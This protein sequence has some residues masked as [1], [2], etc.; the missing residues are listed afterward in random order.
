M[1][2]MFTLCM[3]RVLANILISCCAKSQY[4][5]SLISSLET[6]PQQM[7]DSLLQ[8]HIPIFLNRKLL[9]LHVFLYIQ[10]KY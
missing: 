3:E 8:C 2:Y 1:I 5:F 9:Y 7:V 10:K 4:I 6:L